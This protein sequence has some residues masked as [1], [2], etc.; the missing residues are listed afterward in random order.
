MDN[1]IRRNDKNLIPVINEQSVDIIACIKILEGGR[2]VYLVDNDGKYLGK[3]L[4]SSHCCFEH[5]DLGNIRPDY[6]TIPY[7]VF[8][9]QINDENRLEAQT[10]AKQAFEKHQECNELPIINSSDYILSLA[11]KA[12][13]E[14]EANNMHWELFS[15][16][17]KE[18]SEKKI[19]V[20][21][22]DNPG[23]ASFVKAFRGR[24]SVEPLTKE[25]IL[26]AFS[27]STDSLL[28]YENDIFP[29]CT[30]VSLRD[31]YD[32]M[33]SSLLFLIDDDA[34]DVRGYLKND[35]PLC[36][37]SSHDKKGGIN[38][39][40][41][42]SYDLEQYLI[43][44]ALD[45]YEI[46]RKLDNLGIKRYVHFHEVRSLNLNVEEVIKGL[47]DGECGT[48][49][50]N[51][52]MYVS[53]SDFN[54]K[55]TNNNSAFK[56]KF[57]VATIMKDAGD[58][59]KEWL[60][61]YLLAGVD[62]FYFYDHESIDDTKKILQPYID[63]GLVDY[64]IWPDEM[65]LMS[66]YNDAIVKSRFKTEYLAIID[67]D[68]FLLPLVNESLSSIV[69]KIFVDNKHAGGLCVTWR[70]FGS[71]GYVNKPIEGTLRAFCKRE[72]DKKLRARHG[73]LIINP[74][75]VLYML[76]PHYAEYIVGYHQISEYGD[77]LFRNYN[78]KSDCM[79]C[80]NHYMVKS[81]EEWKIRRGRIPADNRKSSMRPDS[82][83]SVLNS[84]TNDIYDDSILRYASA[85]KSINSKVCLENINSN[86]E[87]YDFLFNRILGEAYLG[88][89]TI[90][91]SDIEQ[92]YAWFYNHIGLDETGNNKDYEDAEILLFCL[93]LRRLM[94]V[95]LIN[96]SDL[97]MLYAFI[98][99]E[100]YIKI[101]DLL[102]KNMKDI[103]YN[104]STCNDVSL[105]PR[106]INVHALLCARLDIRCS[107]GN[108]LQVLG[109]ERN[110]VKIDLYNNRT[111][112][113]VHGWDGSMFLRIKCTADDTV[114]L[115]ARGI[116]VQDKNGA[117]F[118][119]KVTYSSIMISYTVEKISNPIDVTYEDEYKVT[120]KA[121]KDKYI[122]LIVKYKPYEYSC[123]EMMNILGFLSKSSFIREM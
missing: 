6:K 77:Q 25:N 15:V 55:N 8:E 69:D 107:D 86:D 72:D 106:Y 88:K 115:R 13:V 46:E 2:N 58:Y 54:G 90:L 84:Y 43:V 38:V 34:G 73:K 44:I 113:T 108:T 19:Y 5:D 10:L 40:S 116:D 80:L 111:G 23:L 83:F 79:I 7:I 65:G 122:D 9:K 81:A 37:V 51:R 3:G 76:D 91:K 36:L 47:K 78:T 95:G 63:K 98:L 104:D 53:N 21:T 66:A 87:S 89:N 45:D 75:R 85:R 50:L 56:Y 4:S 60:D 62:H 92:L 118:P 117:H 121:T 96:T 68:E 24:L 112:A 114:T 12:L 70:L 30:K 120:F 123:D 17:P 102:C 27:D 103:L 101:N 109:G 49:S 61:Y 26:E 119:L 94:S 48:F 99:N 39:E 28:V 41:L 11:K 64:C 57:A 110:S 93:C 14:R 35:A 52:H 74:R 29:E 105:A 33:L 97:Q 1:D 20:S 82:Q 32:D 71:S 31:L 42:A 16:L 59:L 67:D 18:L 100:K 22:I